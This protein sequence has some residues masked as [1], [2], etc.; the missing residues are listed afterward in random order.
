MTILHALVLGVVE[1]LTEFL[2][3]SSTAHLEISSHLL[4]L[5]QTDFL[6]SFIIII[7]LGAILAVI[8]L[9]AKRLSHNI[10][11]WKRIIVAFIPTGVIGFV[12]YKLIKQYLLGNL[13]IVVWSLAVGG[14]V[15]IAFEYVYKNDGDESGDRELEKM[16]YS[17]AALIGIAQA[18]AVIPGVSRSAATIIAGR[19]LG[20]GRRAVVEFSFLLA[21]PTMIMATGYDVLKNGASFR[22]DDIWLLAVG[23]VAA[24]VSAVFAI[25]Y[26]LR[27][28]QRKSFAIFGIYRILLAIA[29][30]IFLI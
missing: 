27:I 7:Q 1:G 21:I 19:A 11:L 3:I 6:K 28:V 15:L 10:E 17:T 29:L 22:G 9:Y 24:F 4:L 25:R 16:P 23:F 14:L 12:L 20:L 2:P 13:T 8:V 26:F 30:I 5:S 18:L